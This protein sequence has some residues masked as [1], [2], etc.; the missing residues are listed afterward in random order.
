MAPAFVDL[1]VGRM[2][3]KRRLAHVRD[4]TQQLKESMMALGADAIIWLGAFAPG[5]LH[6]AAARAVSRGPW[7]NLVVSNIPGPSSRCT[8]PVRA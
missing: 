2:G 8:S 1:P 4:G 3:P 5:G 6:A 7:F